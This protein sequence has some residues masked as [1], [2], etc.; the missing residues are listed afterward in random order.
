MQHVEEV[1][2]DKRLDNELVDV[3]LRIERGGGPTRE[4]G[5]GLPRTAAV[6]TDEP[7]FPLLREGG[8]C[9]GERTQLDVIALVLTKD[10]TVVSGR[11]SGF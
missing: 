3:M 10:N 11:R 2:L 1:V 7:K 5:L 8:Q 9:A 4:P 6:L